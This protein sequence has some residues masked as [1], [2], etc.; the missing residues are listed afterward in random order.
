MFLD[1]GLQCGGQLHANKIY[2]GTG[3]GLAHCKKIIEMHN[4]KIWVESQPENGSC[5]KF[6]IPM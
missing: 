5:F 4:G 3:I 1:Q 2:P 6:T